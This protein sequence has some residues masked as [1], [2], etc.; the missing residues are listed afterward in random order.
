MKIYS[1]EVV[2]AVFALTPALFSQQI[3][4]SPYI[5]PGD[6]GPLGPTD[7]MIVAWQTDETAPR[8]NTYHVEYGTTTAYGSSAVVTGRVVDNY[9]AADSSLPV[10][11]YSYG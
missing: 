6:N 4:Y 2:L 9:L 1:L 7:Q 8:A 5:Q 10:S 11:P 3:T